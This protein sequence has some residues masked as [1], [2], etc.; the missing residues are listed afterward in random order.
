[1]ENGTEILIKV[2]IKRV[3]INAK[4]GLLRVGDV[5]EIQTVNF[6]RRSRGIIKKEETFIKRI[7]LCEG[8]R[9]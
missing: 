8:K 3:E 9:M 4:K 6:Y 2:T 5:K 1:M 7:I